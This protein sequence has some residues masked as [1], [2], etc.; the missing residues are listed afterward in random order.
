MIRLEKVTK[1]YPM[2][3]IDVAAL[4]SINLEI[5]DREFVAIVGPSGSGKSTLMHLIGLLDRPTRGRVFLGGRDV[6]KI[7]EEKR[8]ELRN[9][10]IGFVFQTFNLLPRASALDN[11]S[12]PLVYSGMKSQERAVRATEALRRVGLEHRLRHHPS[13]LSGGE[14]Q[15]VAIARAL[16]NNPSIILAD[17]PTGNLDTRSGRE[18]LRL[19]K[20]LNK[21]GDTV[22]LVTHELAL[23]RSATRII[24]IKDGEVQRDRK[25]K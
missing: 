24:K 6:S 3:D 8:A 21:S 15:R 12:M 22:V 20:D 11:V 9:K 7:S 16:V 2:G 17:E 1:V 4:R 23:A 19:L 14:Q 5:K 25:R 18:I 10:H 13:Q